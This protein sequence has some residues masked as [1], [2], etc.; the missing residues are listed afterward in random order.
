[1]EAVLDRMQ[2]LGSVQ[3]LQAHNVQCS[4]QCTVHSAESRCTSAL[5]CRDPDSNLNS[6][7]I[8]NA[9]PPLLKEDIAT[10]LIVSFST[11]IIYYGFRFRLYF[12]RI[13]Q[14]VKI[15]QMLKKSFLGLIEPLQLFWHHYLVNCT[16]DKLGTD[17]ATKSDEFSKKFQTAF[18]PPPPL[19][20]GKLYC[21]FYKGSSKKKLYFLG[22]IPKPVDPPPSLILWTFP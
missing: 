8:F 18:D 15:K 6:G 16:N 21:N 1:M 17:G 9:P 13:A 22:I 2:W 10:C 5:H 4:A 7:A 11:G 12:A 19:I 20:F 14:N 3:D